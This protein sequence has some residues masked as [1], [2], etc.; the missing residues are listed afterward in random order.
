ML[1][2][3]AGRT[4]ELLFNIT[5]LN[6]QPKHARLKLLLFPWIHSHKGRRLFLIELK[7][8]FS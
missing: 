5:R 7:A 4:G 2:S 3:V 1:A 8:L 6:A